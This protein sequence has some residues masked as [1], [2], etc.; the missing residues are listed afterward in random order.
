MMVD[1]IT[2]VFADHQATEVRVQLSGEPAFAAGFR[3]GE[4][5][6]LHA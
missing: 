3:S 6:Y 5:Q 2:H 4:H 1:E